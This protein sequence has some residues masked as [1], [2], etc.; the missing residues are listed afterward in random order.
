M[1]SCVGG[2][3]GKWTEC[4]HDIW[5]QGRPRLQRLNH[6]LLQLQIHIEICIS[7]ISKSRPKYHEAL[8]LLTVRVIMYLYMNA[9]ESS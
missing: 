5:P 1:Y 9:L 2:W 8:K 3:V 6:G 7:H 4:M